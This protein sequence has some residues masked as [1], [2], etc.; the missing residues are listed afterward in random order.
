M[1]NVIEQY[2]NMLNWPSTCLILKLVQMS[3]TNILIIWLLFKK[4]YFKRRRNMSDIC[5]T[6]VCSFFLNSKDI[7]NLYNK[8]S[9]K[10]LSVKRKI[11]QY[12]WYSRKILY[13][14]CKK[15]ENNL[16]V[17]FKNKSLLPLTKCSIFDNI[18]AFK[19]NIT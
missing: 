7:C 3:N 6:K 12:R 5:F 17:A 19:F 9:L 18:I 11:K 13:Y 8:Y 2:L 15:F 16:K 10:V 14:L 1:N 4:F